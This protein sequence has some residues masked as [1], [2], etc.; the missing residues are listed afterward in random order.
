MQDSR[1]GSRPGHFDSA[2]TTNT[3]T[4]GSTPE[5]AKGSFLIGDLSEVPMIIQRLAPEDHYDLEGKTFRHSDYVLETHIYFDPRKGVDSTDGF[6]KTAMY[7]PPTELEAKG[8][9]LVKPAFKGEPPKAI[10]VYFGLIRDISPSVRITKP[11]FGIP[12]EIPADLWEDDDGYDSD[13]SCNDECEES[14]H[15]PDDPGPLGPGTKMKPKEVSFIAIPHGGVTSHIGYT[16][17]EICSGEFLTRAR[18]RVT[19]DAH[20][21][22]NMVRLQSGLPPVNLRVPTNG[23]GQVKEP[24]PPDIPSG[25]PSKEGYPPIVAYQQSSVVPS[26]GTSNQSVSLIGTTVATTVSVNIGIPR[27]GPDKPLSETEG[28]AYG[29]KL[30]GESQRLEA[31]RSSLSSQQRQGFVPKRKLGDKSKVKKTLDKG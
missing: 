17:L 15:I 23:G 18:V 27:K 3:D 13:G 30:I 10:P 14:P 11:T 4:R 7:R 31:L 16:Q 19:T 24:V 22:T 8:I 1:L 9:G 29:K 25:K 12:I 20:E 26:A 28:K 2:N 6:F 5:R 21:S